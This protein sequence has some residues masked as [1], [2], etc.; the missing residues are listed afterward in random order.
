[1]TEL[2]ENEFIT[3]MN[4]MLKCPDI[5]L[6]VNEEEFLVCV[7]H[8]ISEDKLVKSCKGK[9]AHTMAQRKNGTGVYTPNKSYYRILEIKRHEKVSDGRIFELSL[10]TNYDPDS[11]TDFSDDKVL[12]NASP[13]FNH[14]SVGPKNMVFEEGMVIH[15]TDNTTLINKT[16][17]VV[18]TVV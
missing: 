12:I 17:R 9:A 18:W 5:K 1:M 4:S 15:V 3:N 7:K 16:Y 13:F 14:A 2:E 10:L 11:G 8:G 6:F